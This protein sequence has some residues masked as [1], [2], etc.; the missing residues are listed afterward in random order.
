LKKAAIAEK[1]AGIF[2]IA[3][4]TAEGVM[5]A[6]S[7]VITIPLVPWIIAS[8]AI[9][10]AIVAAQPIP[11]FALGGGV[12]GPTLG[13]LGEA[14]GISKRNPEFIGTAKQLGLDKIGGQNIQ[15]TLKEAEIDGNKLVWLVDEI[16]RQQ[17]N[18]Y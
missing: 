13:L 2:S 7:K 6:M 8:G 10:A 1:L 17:G 5:D 9:Q 16:K 11:Q 12:S 18:S 15:I 14:P 4:S 3:I